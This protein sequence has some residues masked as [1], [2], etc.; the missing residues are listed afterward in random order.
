MKRLLLALTILTSSV[1]FGQSMIV[2]KTGKVL[3]IDEQGMLYDLSNFL[4]PY[5]IKQMGGRYLIDE[6]RKLRT[7]DRNGL[8]YSKEKEDKVPVNIEYYGENYF[9]SK[10]GKMFTFDE[11]GFLFEAEK[12]REFRN[13]VHKGG[14]FV[15]AEKRV[16][17]KKVLALYVVTNLGKIV[18]VTV[19]GLNLEYVN[20]VGGQYFTTTK[21][22]IY[23]VSGDGFVFSKADMGKF[24][25]WQLK[26]GGNYF[27]V[28]D[29][30][31]SVAQ[32]GILMSVASATD[33]GAIKHFGT[34][35]FITQSGR[36]FTI[37]ASG[38]IRNIPL[39]YKLSDISQFS[40]L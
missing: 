13:V 1:A 19:P 5:Q 34:N 37:S 18:E 36:L 8:M 40:H 6:D 15:I 31:Y 29:S 24:N 28:Q 30:V 33:I 22:V 16:E 14:N 25:G 10:F 35:F 4:L 17:M 26:K 2:M 3:T 39:D 27:I 38:A 9:I 23:T 21:G 11:Q 7:I 20:Y 32:N 12:E